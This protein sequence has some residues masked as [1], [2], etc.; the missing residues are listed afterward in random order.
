MADGRDLTGDSEHQDRRPHDPG[1]RVQLTLN[2]EPVSPLNFEGSQHSEDDR[3]ALSRWR[4]VNLIDGGNELVAI[5]T[6]ADGSQQR[7]TRSLHFAG[8]P[9]RAELLLPE[10]E[11]IADGRTRPRLAMRFLDRWGKPARP[12]TVGYFRVEAPYRSW[13]EVERLRENSVIAI[14]DQ[15]PGFQ[16]GENGIAMIELEPTTRSGEVRLTFEYEREYPQEIRAWLKPAAREWILVGLAEGTLGYQ[17][18]SESIELANDAGFDHGY[19]SDGRIAFF[20]K[21]QVRG[22]VLTAAF[23]S[24]GD[25]DDV[26]LGGVI[27]PDR[28]YVLYGDNTEQRFDAASREKLYLRIEKDAFSALFGDFET[29]MTI[30][31]LSRYSQNADW[32]PG[33]DDRAN[34]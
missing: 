34:A 22:A 2:G 33:R 23:D 25:D 7:I 28:Y 27:D 1:D 29:G 26:P 3:V 17:E 8:P 15:R 11:L 13:S 31:E 10:S 32:F 5:F 19:G 12:D 21:G 24:E 4:G 6:D 16:V 18:I 9:V 14:A 20:A 30:T